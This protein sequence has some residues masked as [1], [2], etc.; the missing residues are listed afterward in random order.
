[1][2]SRRARP[3]PPRRPTAQS[4]ARRPDLLVGAG[5][6][7]PD[8]DAD[9][10]EHLGRP[11]RRLVRA[12]GRTRPWSRRARRRA[13]GSRSW[14]PGRCTPPERSSDGSAWHSE[15]PIV[16]R[17]RT[18]GSAMTRS[19]SWK[20][21]NERAD[22]SAMSSSSRWRGHRADPD[23]APLDPDV[24]ELACRSLMSIRYSRCASRS[25]IIGSRL[26]PPATTRAVPEPVQQRDGVVDAR[27]PLV[28]ERC[29]DL[30]VAFARTLALRAH[31]GSPAISP[32]QPTS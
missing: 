4:P 10:G 21:G 26:C 23:P 20:I 3:P 7:G 8:R 32:C 6:A 18:S 25:F 16:P 9:L 12:R 13:R 14:R 15:P 29:R 24:A 2:P 5:A 31:R 1:M 17:L 30:H 11:D 22:S 19:A 28:L 27:R